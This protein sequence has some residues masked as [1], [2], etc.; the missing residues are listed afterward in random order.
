MDPKARIS[1]DWLGYQWHQLKDQEHAGP[2]L[3]AVVVVLLTYVLYSVS[4]SS[5]PSSSWRHCL[6]HLPDGAQQLTNLD[7]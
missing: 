5:Y 7:R 4:V 1:S 2:V 3:T 6:L